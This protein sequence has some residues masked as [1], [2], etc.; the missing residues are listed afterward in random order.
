[1]K[2]FALKEEDT[3]ADARMWATIS[4]LYLLSLLVEIAIFI[5]VGYATWQFLKWLFGG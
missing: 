1:M 4:I 2:A 3:E 5:V